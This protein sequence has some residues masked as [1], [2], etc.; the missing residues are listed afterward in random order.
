MWIII[1]K[2]GGGILGGLA[3]AW[4]VYAG[5]IRPTTHPNPTTTQKADTITNVNYYITPRPMFGCASVKL[6]RLPQNTT[7]EK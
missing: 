5:L 1:A 7:G 2:W 6:Y 3:L 4:V